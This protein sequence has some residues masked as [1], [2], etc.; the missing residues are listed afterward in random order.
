MNGEL[1]Q[2]FAHQTL[3]LHTHH[4]LVGIDDLV[5][6]AHHQ[7][8]GQA[9]LLIGEDDAVKLHGLP[10]QQTFGLVGGGVLELIEFLKAFIL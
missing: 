1:R 9:G 4:F 6:D 5:T 2:G 8:E 3:H 7:V 10:G